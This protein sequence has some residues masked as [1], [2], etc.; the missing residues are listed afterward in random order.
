MAESGQPNKF[1][2][3]IPIEDGEVKVGE[4][5]VISKLPRPLSKKG[6]ESGGGTFEPVE[7]VE[8]VELVESK[9]AEEAEEA[10][11]SK[12]AEELNYQSGGHVETSIL[13]ED[14]EAEADEEED[15][16]I[17][18][19]SLSEDPNYPEDDQEDDQE[20]GGR[21][22]DPLPDIKIDYLTPDDEEL[23]NS[24]RVLNQV[25]IY[26]DNYRSE[27]YKN[28]KKNLTALY[29][30]YSNKRYII[31]NLDNVI[32]VFKYNTPDKKAQDKGQDKNK[33]NK[34][35]K[36]IKDIKDNK[37]KD[38]KYGDI[39]MELK[40]PEYIYINSSGYFD[41]MQAEISNSRTDLQFHYQKLINKFE[42]KPE[43]KAEFEKARK[44]FIEQLE[45]YYIQSIY[46]TRINGIDLN[47]KI[48]I[49]VLENL[50]YRKESTEVHDVLEGAIYKIDK[51]LV[52]EIN[53]ENSNK[54]NQYNEL[55]AKIQATKDI[56]NNKKLIEEI[57]TYLDRSNINKL[58]KQ[59][60]DIA[61]HQHNYINY[62]VATKPI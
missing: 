59:I 12:E 15:P 31:E 7:S 38:R 61:K 19:T 29:Q 22:L 20:G 62:I 3:P 36:D 10:E 21:E 33:A 13:E 51:K 27:E 60:K 47:N 46:Y 5:E 16:E 1:Q 55:V 14:P 48:N 26:I 54:L 32:T 30:K 57:K 41:N 49:T 8:S 25:R 50:E 37:G 40:Q 11:E 17:G 6:P 58:D 42:V 45:T 56:K 23:I 4:V 39:V 43:E 18:K 34:G 52:E 9:E 53:M 24:E 28:Y 2:E 44:K 35:K